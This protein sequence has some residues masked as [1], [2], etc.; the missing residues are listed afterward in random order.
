MS[1]KPAMQRAASPRCLGAGKS[2]RRGKTPR[3]GTRGERGQLRF[4]LRPFLFIDED[5]PSRPQRFRPVTSPW[6]P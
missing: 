4:T 5:S 1:A 3:D 6:K 2:S